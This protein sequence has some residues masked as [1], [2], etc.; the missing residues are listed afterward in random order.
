MRKILLTTAAL[1]MSTAMAHAAP[2][3]VTGTYNLT[4]TGSAAIT[5]LLANPFS[6]SLDVGTPSAALNFFREIQTSATALDTITASFSITAPGVGS[7]SDTAAEVFSI[8]GNAR[9]DSLTW[10]NAGLIVIN[11]TG[12]SILDIQLSNA[13]YDGAS[14]NYVGLTPTATFTLA[15]GPTAAGVPAPGTLALLSLGLL[16]LAGF[17]IRRR[18]SDMNGTATA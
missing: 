14:G 15:K 11:L 2:I 9:H 5:N 4:Q 13:S 10:A 6:L 8:T 1:L 17:F 12:G 3:T 16:G 7:G 18:K